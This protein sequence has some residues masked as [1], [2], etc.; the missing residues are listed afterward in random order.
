MNRQDII[1]LLSQGI[2]TVEFTKLNGEQRIMTCT[3]DPEWLPTKP[4]VEGKT[5]TDKQLENISVWDTNANG[6]R[7]FKCNRVVTIDNSAVDYAN[8]EKKNNSSKI[9]ISIGD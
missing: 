6:W 8:T 5:L 9:D 7:S 4:I 3:L 2:H 1:T